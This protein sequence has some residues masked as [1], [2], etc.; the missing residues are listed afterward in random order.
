MKWTHIPLALLISALVAPMA[1]EAQ[2]RAS[3]PGH[4]ATRQQTKETRKA[5]KAQLK[6]DLATAKTRVKQGKPYL[7]RQAQLVKQ[8]TRNVLRLQQPR[9]EGRARVEAAFQSYR[10][11]PTA[12][13][14]AFWRSTYA[15]YKPMRDAHESALTLQRQ[16]ISGLDRMKG[17]QQ[18]A[19]ST[20]VDAQAAVK[21]GPPKF[22]RPVYAQAAYGQ[23]ALAPK[24]AGYAVYA[25]APSQSRAG[26][27]APRA[28]SGMF[29][30][31][32]SGTQRPVTT[33]NYQDA[34]DVRGTRTGFSLAPPPP[35]AAP[36]AANLPNVPFRLRQD[37]YEQP[38][39]T[40]D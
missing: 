39:D 4:A 5:Q 12:Q 14:A 36:Y 19:V 22:G 17:Q 20:L 38:W 16:A 32:A 9:V 23:L 28:L 26:Q 35:G 33:N 25:P 24:P 31:G 29:A 37:A 2:R 11:N 8:T 27:A 3:Q 7:Q 30:R 40:L 6:A 13:N 18:K 21:R 1:A 15:D 10:A 34:T